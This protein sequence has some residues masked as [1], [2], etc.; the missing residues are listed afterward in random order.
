MRK[1][2]L[3]AH[4]S[5]DG[6]VAGPNG[7]LDGFEAGEENLEFVCKITEQAGTA[8]FGRVSYQLLDSY[9][10]TARRQ[11]QLCMKVQLNKY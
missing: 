1:L 11:Q 4:T 5:L 2:I 8:V 9:W 3:I 6:F 10:P 7:E